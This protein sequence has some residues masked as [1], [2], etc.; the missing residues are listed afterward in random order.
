MLTIE[1]PVWLRPDSP[2]AELFPAKLHDSPRVSLLGS[3]A[4]AAT[5]SQRVKCQLPDTAG[6]L[7][8]ALPLFLAEQLEFF[9]VAR[10]YTLIPWIESGSGA[11]V[12]SG[13]RWSDEDAA[14]YARQGEVPTIML[15]LFI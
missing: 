8:R 12:V 11:F 6:R 3:T 4:E 1:G 15:S 5:N 10:T 13:V 2:I 9:T 7:S 14:D